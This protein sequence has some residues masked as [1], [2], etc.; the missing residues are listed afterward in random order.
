MFL[1][2][3]FFGNFSALALTLFLASSVQGQLYSNQFGNRYGI[4]SPY[5]FGQYGPYVTRPS[6]GFSRTYSSTTFYSG[7][8][9]NR[10]PYSSQIYVPGRHPLRYSGSL[11]SPYLGNP[12]LRTEGLL[13][14]PQT[15]LSTGQTTNIFNA[16]VNS[17]NPSV[18]VAVTPTG[19]TYQ[20]FYPP[21][22]ENSSAPKQTANAGNTSL[23]ADVVVKVPHPDAEVWFQG[24]KTKQT[25]LVRSYLSPPLKP[26]KKYRYNMKVRWQENGQALE[27][28]RTFLVQAGQQ[29]GIDFTQLE[30][31]P[32]Q[33]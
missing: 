28:T 2:S 26:G 33:P 15:N 18:N 32:N 6:Y 8:G 25:G 27:K 20:S 19:Q 21:V 1:R 31:A 3:T 4:N 5:R 13:Y 16:P 9:L 7:A 11:Y 12:Y 22:Q 30:E 29:V 23:P 24:I 14:N 10:F 17:P